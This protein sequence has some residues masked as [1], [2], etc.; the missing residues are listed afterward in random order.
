MRKWL[1]WSV[2]ILLG[3]GLVG[4]AYE[5]FW[6]LRA[7]ERPP[8]AQVNLTIPEGASVAQIARLASEKGIAG[9]GKIVALNLAS[10]FSAEYPFLTGLPGEA[11]LEG[12]L[13]PDTYTF[14]VGT[15]AK[16][17]IEELLNNF[18]T[19]VIN[20]LAGPL[21]S[22]KRPLHE[23]LAV[24]SLVEKE[25]T[26][27]EN[28]PLAASVI[29][30]RLKL[31]LPLELDSTIVYISGNGSGVFDKGEKL[32]D[33][34]YNTFKKRG[35]PP[36]PIGNP[37]LESIKA[38]L[39]PQGS[40]YLYFLTDRAGQVHFSATLEGHYINRAKFLESLL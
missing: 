22:A 27:K 17:F 32:I 29:Y 2:A 12:Y 39:A 10:E 38:A 34:P 13:F 19:K 7:V 37:G 6:A 15:N 20:A 28:R 14:S 24:A 3:V 36:G 23:I 4:F 35:L 30:N 11:G 31:N 9:R 16:D 5:N 40:D 25:V 26:G 18:K 33:S 21:V 1:F 8:Q